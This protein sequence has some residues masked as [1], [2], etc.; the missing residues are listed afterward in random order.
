MQGKCS[1]ALCHFARSRLGFD[2]WIHFLSFPHLR[3]PPSVVIGS[4]ERS[5]WEER[6]QA[7]SFFHFLKMEVHSTLGTSTSSV[8]VCTAASVFPTSCDRPYAMEPGIDSCPT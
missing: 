8:G 5:R 6:L 3:R 7:F 4:N 1:T 2:E